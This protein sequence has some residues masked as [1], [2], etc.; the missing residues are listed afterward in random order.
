MRISLVI[1]VML[2]FSLPRGG[3][4]ATDIVDDANRAVKAQEN[5]DTHLAFELY[6]S[7]IDQKELK[8]GDSLLT[9][10]LN[11]RAMIFM[12]QGLYDQ[13]I[14]DFDMAVAKKPDAQVLNNRGAAW[15]CKGDDDKAIADFTQ[16]IQLNP[17]YERAYVNRGYALINKGKTQ[18]AMAD[19]QMAKKLDP[20]MNLLEA[21]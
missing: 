7:V 18:Q 14:A 5:G 15:K 9:Y 3:V 2:V 17:R 13:A 16:A 8:L 21:Y 4:C 19:F 11:N 10:V 1:A 6:S 20:K 12:G